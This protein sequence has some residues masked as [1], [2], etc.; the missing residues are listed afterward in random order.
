MIMKTSMGAISSN[1]KMSGHF[2]AMDAVSLPIR[3]S[4]GY[5]RLTNLGTLLRP[6]FQLLLAMTVLASTLESSAHAQGSPL[7]LVTYVSVTPNAVV[8]GATMLVRYRDASRKE[9]DNQRLDVLH[10]T[11]RPNRFVILEV[12]KDEAGF[13]S[14]NKAASTLQFR[15]ELEKIQIAPLDERVSSGIYGRPVKGGDRPGTIYVLTHI[16]VFPRYEVDCL[17]LL[18][19]M[20][21]DTSQDDGNIGYEVLPEADHP[22]HFTVIEEWTTSAFRDAHLVADHTRAF[23][24][25]LLPMEGALYDAR[26]Y[27]ELD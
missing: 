14:H 21:I 5:R 17:A 12:W 22:N 2:I 8:S 24:E 6:I 25:R 16:D 19:T 20:S 9:A 23:R 15:D 10:E 3:A 26:L 18:A 11:T 13:M 1:L 7:Y 4:R 27:N